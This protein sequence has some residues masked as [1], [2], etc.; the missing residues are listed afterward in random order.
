[1]VVKKLT[2]LFFILTILSLVW[3]RIRISPDPDQSVGQ[4]KRVVIVH[5]WKGNPE[6]DWLPWLKHELEERSY[7]VVIPAMPNSSNPDLTQ[8]LYCLKKNIGR[9]DGNTYLVGHSLG[10]NAILH[11][12]SQAP[13]GKS[14]KVILV[15]GFTEPLVIGKEELKNFFEIEL[16]YENIKN[17]AGEIVI[18]NSNNDP[19]VPLEQGLILLQKTG[20]RFKVLYGYKHF[21]SE[22]GVKKLPEVLAEIMKD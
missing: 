20:G 4:G 15:A 12:L 7:M 9:L 17:S 13:N 19:Y 18:I 22:A 3:L 21:N 5:G 10:A 6:A 11:Y 8:W 2:R 16:N 14:A 1:M